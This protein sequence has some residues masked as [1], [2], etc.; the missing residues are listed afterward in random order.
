MKRLMCV[1]AMFGAILLALAGCSAASAGG[2]SGTSTYTLSGSVATPN[3]ATV[4][5]GT[6]VY[7]K[8]VTS[9]GASTAPALYWTRSAF[10]GGGASYSI[11]V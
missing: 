7:L 11:S 6:Y 4:N 9:G 10:S 5:N 1:V 8:L 2:G 3:G